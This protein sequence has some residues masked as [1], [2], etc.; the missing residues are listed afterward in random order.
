MIEDFVS[1]VVVAVRVF[2]VLIEVLEVAV[3]IVVL[4]A[5]GSI[6]CVG[7]IDSGYKWQR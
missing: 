1:L 3:L 2:V 6:V 4:V 5:G 7:C